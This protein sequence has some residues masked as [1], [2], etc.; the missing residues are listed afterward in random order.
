MKI[1]PAIDIINGQCVRLTQ[2]DYS[3]QT[4]Y[5]ADPLDFA[6]M[7]ADSGIRRLH[8]VDLDGAKASK[9][10]NL[11][12][13]ERIATKTDLEVEFGGGIKSSE[14]LRN[15]LESGAKWAICGSI[16]VTD[17][18]KLDSW[19]DIHGAEKI[20]L[21]ADVRDGKIA[22][23][24]WYDK[25]EITATELIRRFNSLKQIIITDI[26]KDGMMTGPAFE[27][28]QQLQNEMPDKDIIVSGGVSSMDDIKRLTAMG[29][30]Y[31][32]AGKSIYEGKITLE[33]VSKTNNSL[34]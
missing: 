23:N 12:I 18:E 13:L 5:F 9:P 20:I 15:V 16:A 27:M 31:A 14:S 1:I 7:V 24:G 22:I 11:A 25:S 32:I 33:D 28:Y 6:K 4:T 17:P 3:Q 8:L 10:M 30:R 21:G 2:G 26:S 19:I 34:S 29:L